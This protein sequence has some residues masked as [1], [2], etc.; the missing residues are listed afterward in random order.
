MPGVRA[1]IH[2]YI[3]VQIHGNMA[4]GAGRRYAGVD[5]AYMAGFVHTYIQRT[6]EY[7]QVGRAYAKEG[8]AWRRYSEEELTMSRD[9]AT[10]QH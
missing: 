3:H 2:M 4:G 10:I 1:G 8:A 6:G 5:E 7:Q 9:Q